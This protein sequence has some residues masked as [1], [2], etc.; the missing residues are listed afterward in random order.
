MDAEKEKGELRETVREGERECGRRGGGSE[1]GRA[2]RRVTVEEGVGRLLH[3][4]V[5]TP[6]SSEQARPSTRVQP[7][8]RRRRRCRRGLSHK[9]Y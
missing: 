4:A 6:Y 7:P 3:L 8:R 1:I 5:S 9:K 2:S